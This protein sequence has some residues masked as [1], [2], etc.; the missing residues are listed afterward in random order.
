MFWIL[1][2]ATDCFLLLRIVV[3]IRLVFNIC[4]VLA[5]LASWLS[6]LSLYGG[7]EYKAT[8]HF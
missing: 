8:S 2:L 5:V 7:K 3:A 1:K 6:V 4:K